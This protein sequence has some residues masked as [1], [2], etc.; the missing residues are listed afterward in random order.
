VT[1]PRFV[2]VVADR[3]AVAILSA[4][5]P[6]NPFAT[7][8]YFDARQRLGD[9]LWLLQMV[10]SEDR[11]AAGC[12]AFFRKRLVD[13][14]LD[15]PSLP[16]VDAG[17]SFWPG[18]VE[19]CREQRVT[20][21]TLG[22]YA[23][24]QGIEIP[25][26]STH[27]ARKDRCEYVLD[28]TGDIDARIDRRHR[29][30][31]KKAVRAGLAVRRTRAVDAVH[32][33]RA[34]M[35]SSMDRR[36]ARG[37][38]VPTIGPSDEFEALLASGAGE[39]YQAVDGATVVASGL[40]LRAPKGVYFHSRGTSPQGMASGASH[41]LLYRMMQEFGDEGVTTF[42]IGG[43]DEGSGLARFK[44]KFGASQ[45]PLPSARCSL[46]ATWQR[47][48]NRA[49]GLARSDPKALRRLLTGT[50][51]RRLVFAVDTA[52]SEP[53]EPRGGMSFRY[54]TPDDLRSLSTRDPSFRARQLDRLLR[55]GQSYAYGVVAEGEVAFVCWL[56]PPDSVERDV[57]PGVLRVRADEAVIEASETQQDFRGRGLAGYGMR[58]V[59]EVAREQGVRRLLT[60]VEPSN[61]ASQS[62]VRKAGMEP[63]GSILL[64]AL[65]LVR[66]LV[67]WR[68]YG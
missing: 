39:L 17:S 63:A 40:V 30:H 55:F 41:F 43:A 18:L 47:R 37:E 10:D 31:I 14:R 15:I 11:L 60:K 50:V 38:D 21:V 26:L 12:G 44:K 8:A 54:L 28:L 32:T 33:H 22:T 34:M 65:P 1:D 67:I 29:Q 20:R 62:A 36:R 42:N 68:R 27:C 24:P 7:P 66:K 23:S 52:K 5:V 48:M 2:A 51:T 25:T 46:G 4:L 16:L 61:L 3:D 9:K 58:K 53:P 49:L 6:T 19:F 59:I 13:R 57:P 56:L 45:V 64:I 35:D